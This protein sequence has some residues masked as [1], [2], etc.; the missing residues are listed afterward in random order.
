M[1]DDIEY[2]GIRTLQGKGGSVVISIPRAEL[3]ECLDLDPEALEGE[4]VMAWLYS[5]G[6]FR[7]DLPENTD[8]KATSD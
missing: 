5:D 1:S 3:R 4:K 2:A 6:S 8:A 7:C